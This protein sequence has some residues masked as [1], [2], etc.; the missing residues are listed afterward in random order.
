MRG[1]PGV[2]VAVLKGAIMKKQEKQEKEQRDDALFEALGKNKKKRRRRIVIT[3]ISV[4]LVLAIAA[5]VG[6]SFLQ[7]KVREQFASSSGEVLSYTVSTGTISTVVSG[8]GSLADV[9]T[10][11]VS[12]PEGVEITGV[13]VKNNDA[14]AEGTVLATVDMASVKGAMADLQTRIEELDRQISQAEADE[15]GT[16][17]EAGVSGRLKA[18]FAQPGDNVA[19]VMYAHGALAVV[20]LDGYM[21]VDIENESLS[22]GETVT[23]ALSDG[24]IV[25][26]TV[27]TASGGTVTVLVT[28]NGPEYD[29]TVTV[30]DGE[31]VQTGTGNLYIHSPLRV[32]GFAGTVSKVRVKLNAKVSEG[33]AL[34]TLTDTSHSANYDSLLR[35][36][37]ALEEELLELLS[38]QQN[39]AVL[40]PNAGS[41]YSVDYTQGGTDV[42]T[43]SRDESMSV[44]ISVDEGD[45]L[46]LELGQT[47]SVTVSAVSDSAF[48]GT[49]TEISKTATDGVYSAVVT[50]N[51]QEGM[52]SGMTASVS[53]QIEGVENALLIPLEALHQTSTGA[54]VY[55]SYDEELQEYGGKRDVVIGIS[56]SSYVE[57][58]S[59]L[60]EGDTVFYTEAVS[61]GNMGSFGGRGDREGFGGDSGQTPGFSGGQM[62]GSNGGQIPGF[63][64]GQTPGGSG[65]GGRN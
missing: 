50:L 55:T 33:T 45:I 59:G 51:K 19:D 38:I 46:S 30:F 32:T 49:L 34:F 2:M 20:S 1:V 43:L 22:E 7:S 63:S 37:S 4:V 53:V 8:S 64:G 9:D 61:Y 18:V 16:T 25:S 57:I 42:V 35:S 27:E 44:S 62:P 24:T 3:V 14:V 40:A 65:R 6:V 28:D 52:L 13:L 12:V 26:G 23:V 56:N 5:A 41:V 58:K 60:S 48:M 54:Y 39:G 36:R 15:V 10:V 17:V 21:A 31:G 29:D 11:S 47:V